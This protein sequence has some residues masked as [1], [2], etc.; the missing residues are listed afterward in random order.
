[1]FWHPLRSSYGIHREQANFSRAPV[2]QCNHKP[3]LEA[4][5]CWAELRKLARD[6]R[7]A[8]GSS[9][10]PVVINSSPPHLWN[11]VPIYYQNWSLGCAAFSWGLEAG[12]SSWWHHWQWLQSLNPSD[13]LARAHSWRVRS[14]WVNYSSGPYPGRPNPQLWGWASPAGL[15]PVLRTLP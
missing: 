4:S 5:G 1:M 14:G 6:C 3:T 9:G 13:Y 8:G 2:Q 11:S 15:S 10:L 7:Q 12:F